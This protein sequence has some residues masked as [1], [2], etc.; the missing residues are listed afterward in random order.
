MNDNFD[1]YEYKD[2]LKS[3]LREQSLTGRDASTK[4]IAFLRDSI[5]PKLDDA[6]MDEFI[7]DMCEHM[8]VEPPA[9]RLGEGSG[10]RQKVVSLDDLTFDLLDSMFDD[11]TPGIGG[12]RFP[13][14]TD[15][16]TMV[17]DEDSLEQ[18]KL[19]TKSKYGNVNMKIDVEASAPWDKV[20]VL[21]DKFIEDKNRYIDGKAAALKD[22]GTNV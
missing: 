21:D 11:I 19:E 1:L 4:V 3:K 17:G 9:Y 8:D 14:N 7:I 13:T 5:Y 15:A 10:P 2:Q 12:L 18:W 20:K 6:G 16:S 22:M